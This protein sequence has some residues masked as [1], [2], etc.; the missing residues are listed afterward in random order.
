MLLLTKQK[1]GG[2]LSMRIGL[3]LFLPGF[4]ICFILFFKNLV[5][6][7]REREN[8]TEVKYT[9]QKNNKSKYILKSR[10]I[11]DSLHIYN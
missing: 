2:A 8:S 4:S 11:L 3:L 5:Q 1:E 7:L 6:E 9:F 10:G